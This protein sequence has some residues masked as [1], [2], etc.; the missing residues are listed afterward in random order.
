MDPP[1]HM[2]ATRHNGLSC[3]VDCCQSS[4]DLYMRSSKSY[5]LDQAAASGKCEKSVTRSFTLRTTK[6]SIA[7]AQNVNY[8]AH[9]QTQTR[10][11]S[12]PP[13]GLYPQFS[14]DTPNHLKFKGGYQGVFTGGVYVIVMEGVI[15]VVK[16]WHE[17]IYL[18]YETNSA[19][20]LVILFSGIL[21]K[22][23]PPDVIFC[24]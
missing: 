13:R 8:P 19:Q 23:L 11:L 18:L 7:S 24:S 20:I 3:N 15:N 4:D 10:D 2:P 17:P 6:I 9:W 12:R 5:P 16:Y 22:L 1:L 14:C 21:L